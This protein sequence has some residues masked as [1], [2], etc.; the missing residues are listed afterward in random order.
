MQVVRPPHK[1]SDDQGHRTR[2]PVASYD[3]KGVDSG[4]G[5]PGFES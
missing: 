1:G 3:A 2:R 4:T 5:P